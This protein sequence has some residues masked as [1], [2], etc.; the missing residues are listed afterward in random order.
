MIMRLIEH[1]LETFRSQDYTEFETVCTAIQYLAKNY[2]SIDSFEQ[3]KEQLL[4]L[5]QN[6][7][8]IVM[9]TKDENTEYCAVA[10]FCIA[11]VFYVN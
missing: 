4:Q 9:Q 7:V 1:Y 2:S 5:F 3:C 11:D 10:L 8:Q 6:I